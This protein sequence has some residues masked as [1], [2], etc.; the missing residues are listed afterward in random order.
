MDDARTPA[1]PPADTA[2]APAGEPAPPAG[3]E[4]G[5]ADAKGRPK[6]AKS[7]QTR[8]LILETAMRLFQERGYD[9]TTM[10]AIAAEAGVSVGNAYYYYEGKEFLIQGFYDRMTREH[11]VEAR[12]RMAGTTDFAERLRV[13]IEAWVDCAAPYHEFAAQF[14]RTAADPES[15]LSP[16]SND[17][18]PARETAVQIFREVL[19]GSD[20]GPKIDP[21]LDELLPDLLWLHLMVVVLYWV[22]DRTEDTERTR[23]FVQRCAPFVAKIVSLSRY[24]VFRPLVRDAVGMVEDFVLPTIGRTAS[25]RSP[26]APARKRRR[27]D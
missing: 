27:R 4:P 15:A 9:K 6:T 23:A 2:A 11:A 1:D 21:E 19:D 24:R 14:F 8:A 16:F 20:L 12:A 7:E 5:P 22:F 26:A 10:R 18:H 25:T 3:A 17:S 13:A